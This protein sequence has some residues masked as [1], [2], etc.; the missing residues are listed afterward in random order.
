MIC[1]PLSVWCVFT[2]RLKPCYQT[3]V[4]ALWLYGKL[5]ASVLK[6]EELFSYNQYKL[7]GQK[8]ND[9]GTPLVDHTHKGGGILCCLPERFAASASPGPLLSCRTEPVV[10]GGHSCAQGRGHCPA[11]KPW[12]AEEGWPTTT[13]WWLGRLTCEHMWDPPHPGKSHWCLGV[14]GVGQ[15]WGSHMNGISEWERAGGRSPQ[16]MDNR[17]R[18]RG[19][20]SLS[21]L[22]QKEPSDF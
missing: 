5:G 11:K 13:R 6:W 4:D 8:E 1:R 21:P 14:F 20:P 7:F 16:I 9:C 12:A 17:F 15:E 3:P 18:R 2:Y 10:P 22:L 19:F